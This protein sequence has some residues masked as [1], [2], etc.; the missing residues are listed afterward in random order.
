MVESAAL[1]KRCGASH[2]GFES[3]PLR[4]NN[5]DQNN[6]LSYLLGASKITDQD[7]LNLNIYIVEKP[8]SGSRKIEIP[9][10]SIEEYKNL[11]KIKLDPG[12]WNE[13]ISKNE[14]YFIFK[15][16][17]SAIKEFELSPD[18]EQEIDDLCARF[19]SEPPDKTANI[20]KY[21]SENEFYHN[22]MYRH[23]QVLIER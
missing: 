6:Y 2:R 9:N 4:M 22:L 14:I 10:K 23:Y 19:N 1:E 15:F 3:L 5:A 21:L 17:D 18:N 8:E 12:F 11:I 7:L 13:C 16:K 20:Y